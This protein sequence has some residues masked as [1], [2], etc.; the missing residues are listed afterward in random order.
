MW[1]SQAWAAFE[2]GATAFPRSGVPAW[3]RS[4]LALSPRLS[5]ITQTERTAWYTDLL[6]RTINPTPLLVC[7]GLRKQGVIFLVQIPPSSPI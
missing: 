1:S 5:V 2:A 7:A 3:P 4:E 6:G